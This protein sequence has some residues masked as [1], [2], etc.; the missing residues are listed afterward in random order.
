[1]NLYTKNLLLVYVFSFVK[2]SCCQELEPGL[3]KDATLSITSTDVPQTTKLEEITKSLPI[4]SGESILVKSTASNESLENSSESNNEI[5]GSHNDYICKSLDGLFPDPQHRHKFI[6][7]FGGRPTR[8]E[9]E[10]LGTVYDE[11]QQI[12][13]RETDEL[14][15]SLQFFKVFIWFVDATR[16]SENSTRSMEKWEGWEVYVKVTLTAVIV[17]ILNTMT[18][19]G[20][21]LLFRTKV[22]KPSYNDI[23][24]FISDINEF[25]GYR[26][27]RPSCPTTVELDSLRP[28]SL[29]LDRII[30]ADRRHYATTRL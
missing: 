6:H 23:D 26:Y 14:P 21:Y 3:V 16:S 15:I 2:P 18:V 7:C 8:R 30:I 1:M 22:S 29:H 13:I 17:L 9:C 4:D 27:Y 20:L 12:C 25:R 11:E 10:P 24:P 5:Y 19:F 28:S